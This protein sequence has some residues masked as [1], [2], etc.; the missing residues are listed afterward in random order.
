MNREQTKS[1]CT[2]EMVINS[3]NTGT[4][5]QFFQD[6]QIQS[7]LHALLKDV[8]TEKQLQVMLEKSEQHVKRKG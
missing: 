7:I 8:F 3:L 5:L 4:S 6:C 1:N 2:V